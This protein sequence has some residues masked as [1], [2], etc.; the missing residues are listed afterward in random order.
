MP[1]INIFLAEGRTVEQKRKM[2][3]RITKVVSEDAIVP[4]EAVHILFIDMPQTN[5]ANAGVLISDK[6]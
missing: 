3:D 6:K 4:K 2:A 5:V 1:Y